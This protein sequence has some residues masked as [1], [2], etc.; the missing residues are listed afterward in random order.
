AQRT[1]LDYLLENVLDPSAVVAR[2]YTVTIIEL[3]NGRTL[4]GI[5]AEETLAALTVLTQN[6]RLVVAKADIETQTPT[7][8][9]LMPEGLLDK[10]TNAEVRDLVGYLMRK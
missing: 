8:I 3:K 10:L 9:S 2:E 4:N 7:R 1:N 6:E 5:I